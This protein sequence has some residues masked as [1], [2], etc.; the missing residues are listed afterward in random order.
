MATLNPFDLLGD[1][2]NED[3][4]QLIAAAQQLKVEKPKK[5]LAPAPAQPA[6]LPSKP[7]P[8]AEAV[9]EAKNEVGRGGGRG[10]GRGFG[11]GRGGGGFNRDSRSNDNSF[12]NSNGFSGGYR[13]SEEGDAGKSSERRGSIV[14]R[15]PYRGGRRGSFGNEND[16]EGE[17]PRRIY[18]RRSGT[19]RGN[20]VKRDGAGRGNWGTPSD[21]IPSETEEP[22]IENETNVGTE[23]QPVEE[24]AVDANKESPSKEPE[25]KEPDEN[26]V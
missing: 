23:K 8:P 11:R 5:G 19:G 16:G 21:E 13:P 9:R 25:E 7:A 26:K 10:G 1:D 18:E 14:P 4:S 12:G 22:V 24:D 15:G 6:K 20:E 2:D 3:P 17:R